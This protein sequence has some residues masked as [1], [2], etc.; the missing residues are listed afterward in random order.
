MA[1]TPGTRL[2]HYDV[3]APLGAGGMGFVYRAHDP[4]LG[5]D[6]ALKFLAEE[7]LH[8]PT[9]VER[10]IREARAASALNHPNIVTIYEIGETDHGRYIVMEL[11]A[12]RTLRE[13]ATQ[14]PTI[15]EIAKLAEQMARALATAHAAGIVHRDIKPENIMVR[16]D[17]YVKL[18][19][20]GLARL[21]SPG[22]GKD[23]VSGGGRTV[24]GMVLGTV[25]YMSPEQASGEPVDSASDVFSLG[26]VLYELVT[27]LN[28]FA[29]DSPIGVLHAILSRPPVPPAHLNRLIPSTL[30]GLLLE[31]L[32]K[33]PQLRPTASDLVKRFTD[34]SRLP[35]TTGEIA[36]AMPSTRH[37]VGRSEEGAQLTAAFDAAATGRGLLL[38]VAGEPGIG[39]TTVVDDFLLRLGAAQP[40]L[41]IARGRCSERLAGTDAFL[42]FVEALSS[43]LHGERSDTAAHAMPLLAPTWYSRLAPL[44]S[45]PSTSVA[46]AAARGATN[47]RMKPEIA[48]LLQE[49]SRTS[50]LVVSLE[51]LHW[52]DA[53]T[54]E[55]LDYL[56][57]RFDTLRMLIVVTYRPTEL[58]LLK[59]PFLSIKLDLQARGLAREIQLGFLSKQDVARYVALEFPEHDFPI[60]LAE[61]IHAKTEGS[62][63]FMA[64]LVS[65]LRRRGV[66]VEEKGRWRLAQSVPDIEKE[67]PE[68]V[69]SMIQRKIDSVTEDDRKLLIAA[70]VQGYEF[71]SAVVAKALG[72]DQAEVEDGFDALERVHAFVRFE[73]E[74]ELPDRSVTVR[75]RFVHVL[76]QN[77]LYS[78]LRAT[79]RAS[80]SAAVGQAL[81]TFHAG[82]TAAIASRL[83]F[84]F[85][86]ARDYSRAA[87]FFLSAA[88]QASRVFANQEASALARRGLQALQALPDGP[89]SQRREL[90]L[91]VALAGPLTALRGYADPEV[92]QTYNRARELCRLLGDAPQLF[93]VLHGLYR[94]YIVK[95]EL[96]TSREVGEQLLAIA[97]RAQ[98]PALLLEAHRALGTPLIYSGEFARALDH[99]DRALAIYDPNSHRS[100]IVLYG[101]DPGL[102]CNAWRAIAL[103]LSGRPDEAVH[104]TERSLTIAGELNH[105]FSL[106]YARILA[107][108]LHQYRREPESVRAHAEAAIAISTEHNL[109]LWLAIGTMLRGWARAASGEVADGITEIRAGLDGFRA[110]GGVLNLPHFLS[111]LAEA[112]GFAGQPTEALAVVSE[113]L[114][115]VAHQGDKCYEAELNRLEGVL[116]LQQGRPDAQAEECFD[117]ALEIARAQ[118][119]LSL[120]LRAATSLAEL[121]ART[122][123]GEEGRVRLREVLD[124]FTEGFETPDLTQARA[125][126][127]N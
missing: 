68:S 52:A 26:I 31:M 92:A 63:L 19:D 70:S 127:S 58:Q 14:Q 75:Y 71:D 21:I 125:A 30:E 106:A 16:E 91:Q 88:Q 61:L 17:G 51:D 78:S 7:L 56:A 103:W 74:K 73:S 110:T 50:P 112:H 102:A 105:P 89:E 2:A 24:P 18:V 4:R 81:A 83:A 101:A 33:D 119:A 36:L 64:D 96:R 5:R 6:V 79:R 84:L 93:P 35:R 38:C 95:G 120:E 57:N 108:W 20:F 109:A 121:C 54:V 76:Y 67:L 123:R 98:D 46:A 72:A 69:R 55:L 114:S 117:Q 45:D 94:F 49:L 60:A 39:K 118:N 43:L 126:L 27:G 10:F 12:G 97:D 8:D 23:D 59:H 104:A 124:R 44:M 99:L 11:V 25:R 32:Q 107:G 113:A 3:V 77:A 34:L 41:R 90:Q 62:P 65:D 9:A 116:L 87:E 66:V 15:A 40:D 48:A 29:A 85:E 111:L 22:I 100:H 28:P 13:L 47:D 53:S 1:L 80:L 42:P 122:D 82:H 37:T 86:A 115:V